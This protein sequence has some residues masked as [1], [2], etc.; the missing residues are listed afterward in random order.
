MKTKKTFFHVSFLDTWDKTIT[1]SSSRN[2]K[3]NDVVDSFLREELRW[4]LSVQASTGEARSTR[5]YSRE[6]AQ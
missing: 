1:K 2:N 6:R 3:F 5:G 4:I